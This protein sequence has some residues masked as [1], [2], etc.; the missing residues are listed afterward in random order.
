[1]QVPVVMVQIHSVKINKPNNDYCKVCIYVN[2]IYCI[3]IGNCWSEPLQHKSIKPSKAIFGRV[4]LK[5]TVF[6]FHISLVFAKTCGQV[7]LRKKR[8]NKFKDMYL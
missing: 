3:K 6:A 4:N 1:M 8:K 7:V 2:E 5:Y